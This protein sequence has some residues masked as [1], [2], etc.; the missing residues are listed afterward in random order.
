MRIRFIES[1]TLRKRRRA[2]ALIST[3]VLMLLLALLSVGL[4][5]VASTQTRISSK[6]L[7]SMEA[8]AQARLGLEVAIGQLQCELGPDQRI[9]ANSGILMSESS[10]QGNPYIL[11]AWNSFD[12][13][14]NRTTSNGVDIT[15]TYD[16]GRKDLFRSWLI[17]DPDNR[18]LRQIDSG[19]NGLGLRKKNDRK[20]CLV[21]SGTLGTPK[22]SKSKS[23]NNEI[24]AGLIEVEDTLVKDSKQQDTQKYFAWWISGENQKVRVNLP[25][26]NQSQVTDVTKL[27]QSTWNTPGPD[28]QNL[29]LDRLIDFSESS[30][31]QEIQ[32]LVSYDTISLTQRGSLEAQ[33]ILGGL[34]HDVS[35]TANGLLTDSKFGGLKKDLNILLSQETLPEEFQGTNS[36]IGLRPYNEEDG[37]PYESKR[38]IAS[39]NQL[40]LWANV[41]DSN[42]KKGQ[43]ESAVLAW[44]ANK[45]MTY[46]AS[47]PNSSLNIMD[48]RYTY[49]R[50]PILLRFYTFLGFH[51][52]KHPGNNPAV[53][54]GFLSMRCAVNP[55]FVWW[56][57]YN[58]DLKMATASGAPWGSYFGEH[59]FM[60][61]LFGHNIQNGGQPA[62]GM[63]RV[64]EYPI[65]PYIYSPVDRNDRQIA[66]FGASY[67]KTSTLD[68]SGQGKGGDLVTLG[69]GEIVLFSQ[70]VVAGG[71]NKGQNLAYLSRKNG[72]DIKVNNF[73]FKEGWS[74]APEQTGA[75]AV[76]MFSG[77][78]Y[79]YFDGS[80]YSH[81]NGPFKASTQFAQ[82][83][84]ELIGFQQRTDG[85]PTN[86]ILSKK[87]TN[88]F[89]RA[90]QKLGTFVMGA[91][92][93]D[94]NQFGTAT[95]LSGSSTPDPEI[96]K[97]Y[98]PAV[99]NMNWGVWEKPLLD[100]IL[101][102]A[103]VMRDNNGDDENKKKQGFYGTVDD[104][105]LFVTY[106]GVSAK[107]SKSPIIGNYPEDKDYRA[108]TWQHSS[109]LFW[110]SQMVGASE[111]SRTYSPYQFELK[112]VNTTFAPITI[113]NILSND[114]TRL[115]PFGGPGAEQVNKIA[116]AELPWQQP[117]SLAGFAGC[118]LTPGWYQT[119]SLADTAKRFA[120]QSGVPGVGIGNSFADPMIPANKVFSKQNI[121]NDD[122]LADFW[123]HGFMVNDAMWDSWFTSSMATRPKNLGSSNKEE[124]KD[125]I[126]EAFSTPAGKQENKLANKR[127]IPQ[128]QGMSS[129]MIVNELTQKDGYKKTAKY[130][131]VQGAFNVNSVSQR[132]WES[133]LLGLINR[134]L[135]HN[136]SGTP[137]KINN[138]NSSALF[139]RFGITM[140]DKSHIDDYGS[141]GITNG[142][143]MGEAQAWTDLR[144][145]NESQLKDLAKEMV[146][147]VRKRGPFLNMAEFINRR[148]ETGE[149]G[150]KGALQA[151]IDNSKINSVFDELSDTIISPSAGY[152]H[153]E[154]AKGSAYTAAPGYLIQS[155]VLAVLGNILTTRDDTFTIRSYGEVCNPA[156]KVLAKAWC[157]AIVQRSIYYVD[158]SNAPETP[159][160]EINMKT[161]AREESK[162]S[163]INKAFGRKF[164]IVAFRWLSPEE[165]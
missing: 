65:T 42:V 57:P 17:S 38:P 49:V 50:Q 138:S 94:Q 160:Y 136:E 108:K 100:N 44:N 109:P 111:L 128:G 24:Y 40:Y 90:S 150:V 72:H 123:D 149:M 10:T 126:L 81:A 47:D 15:A 152:P 34:F 162:L 92:I 105:S 45:P 2:F 8:K 87:L 142:I 43:D 134:P 112:Q 37:S 121:S 141:V 67:R 129:E 1:K 55:V 161:G 7:L 32:K 145:V 70:P 85:T 96:F 144:R 23:S 140:S 98:S 84:S 4:L 27:A 46:V 137:Q 76:N 117:Y 139:S 110:G 52:Y 89:D 6:N 26:Y 133:I 75:Y 58:V 20:V 68:S 59:R 54:G 114:G 102:P 79:E 12:N 118:R 41:W 125:I 154:A 106:Y 30:Y 88:E 56:N 91:G 95:T 101:L 130:L 148:L 104:D 147:Q 122:T 132:A 48:N 97:Q 82:K 63:V 14:L 103:S 116:A 60:P 16:Q 29:G 163:A 21:G 93:M 115:S 62:A 53:N 18:T 127:F 5:T 158:P 120:Y 71:E 31:D 66:D 153:A 131:T 39:W 25:K 22:R 124:L 86:H 69:A 157:E 35:L 3:I 156:G 51:F 28:I 159:V 83:D 13:Y 64:S 80:G 119:Q 9:S 78:K 107:W 36:D 33:R 164:N 99:L 151:A 155:D 146:N 19:S 143:S 165:I 61:L 77:L 113:G 73:P 11:G 135:L 74:Q